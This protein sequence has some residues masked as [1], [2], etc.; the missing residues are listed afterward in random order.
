MADHAGLRRPGRAR[1]VDERE[2]VVLVDRVGA[3]GELAGMRGRPVASA[4]AQLVE[5]GE[6]DHVAAEAFDLRALLVV[7]DERRRPPPSA[8][9]RTAR[10]VASST[11]R[12]ARRPRRRG[13][14]RSRRAPTRASCARGARTRRLSGRRARAG[15]SRARRPPVPLRRGRPRAIRR[16]TRRGRRGR[17]GPLR[18]RSATGWRSCAFQPRRVRTYP[19]EHRR[20]SAKSGCPTYTSGSTCA[21][22]GTAT[23][24]SV[25]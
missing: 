23:S 2:E 12:S 7:L 3:R 10:R 15:R 13:R 22:P 5:L 19:Q 16:R 21:Q 11:S 6:R 8:R 24:A 20:A 9:G 25:S 4:R 14:A 18:P 1:R 17:G